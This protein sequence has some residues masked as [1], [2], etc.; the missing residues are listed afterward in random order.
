MWSAFRRQEGRTGSTASVFVRRTE[1]QDLHHPF[2][3]FCTLNLIEVVA[4]PPLTHDALHP[5]E[6][7]RLREALAVHGVYADHVKVWQ[8]VSKLRRR[9]G[10]VLRGEPH[11]PG[12]EREAGYRIEEWLWEAQRVRRSV[13]S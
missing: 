3:S 7:L 8:T 13:R 2:V 11:W 12:E 4:S 9:H 1:F 10:L 6:S 5:G